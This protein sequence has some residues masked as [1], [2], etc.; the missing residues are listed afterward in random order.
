[1][2]SADGEGAWRAGGRVG[3]ADFDSAG[4]QA[5]RRTRAS[6]FHAFW[7]PL[8]RLSFEAGGFEVVLVELNPAPGSRSAGPGHRH[9][10]AVL[11]YVVEG[12]LRF[13]I[14][15]E[16][17]KVVPAGGTFFEPSGAVHTS[18]G[19]AKPDGPTRAVVFMLVPKG[20]PLTAPA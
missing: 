17:E 16:P 4:K 8:V 12:Q 9:P 2:P 10:G 15:N 18:N 14:N 5:H 19:S 11:G 7:L 1:M 3:Q 20:S 6:S 13:G